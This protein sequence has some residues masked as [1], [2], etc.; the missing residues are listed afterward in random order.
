MRIGSVICCVLFFFACN[1]KTENRSFKP[2][3]VALLRA[4]NSGIS[5][6][7]SE[8][9]CLT[10]VDNRVFLISNQKRDLLQFAQVKDSLN[11]STDSLLVWNPVSVEQMEF[12][13]NRV[14]EVKEFALQMDPEQTYYILTESADG[15]ES[16]NFFLIKV[17]EEIVNNR[18]DR[19]IDWKAF[20]GI[21][22]KRA[23][24]N[25]L[26]HEAVFFENGYGMPILLSQHELYLMMDA[27][28]ASEYRTYVH[29]IRPDGSFVNRSYN[30][31]KFNDRQDLDMSEWKVLR[32][33]LKNLDS[34]DKIR[35]GQLDGKLRLWSQV[36]VIDELFANPLL[37]YEWQ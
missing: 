29:L 31:D 23:L 3:E 35:I 32:I 27:A 10:Q 26:L 1:P 37:R 12:N 15:A 16:L 13:D 21:D 11:D 8:T 22:P 2:K 30:V 18:G 34:Y 17:G 5:Q 14:L 33:P 9:M 6:K 4:L 7:I 20:L 25:H 28:N 36:L 19:K 24:F